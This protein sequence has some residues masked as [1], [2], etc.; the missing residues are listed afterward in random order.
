MVIL[1][2]EKKVTAAS[3]IF[4]SVLV[5][6]FFILFQGLVHYLTFKS[7][8]LMVYQQISYNMTIDW[9]TPKVKPNVHI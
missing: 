5:F 3:A 7:A 8:G 4:E 9:N 1:F 6:I 2:H